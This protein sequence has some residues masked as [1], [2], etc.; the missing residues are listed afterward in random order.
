MLRKTLTILTIS[1]TPQL[2]LADIGLGVGVSVGDGSVASADVGASVGDGSVASADVGASIGDGS[3]ASADVG[4]TVGDGSVASA[5]IGA[6]VGDGS[7]ASADVGATVG[8]GSVASIGGDATIGGTTG[9]G[10]D[11]GDTNTAAAPRQTTQTPR[12]NT[13]RR[14]GVSVV[15]TSLISRDGVRFGTITQANDELICTSAVC[16]RFA[17]RPVLT[18]EGLVVNV[19]SSALRQ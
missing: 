3:V 11:Q 8:D 6:T 12:T 14:P 5:D 19:D 18:A 7:V 15:G 13:P 1:A 9:A 16:V 4:A 17:S 10:D 2:A